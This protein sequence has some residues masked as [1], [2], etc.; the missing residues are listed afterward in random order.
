MGLY[1]DEAGMVFEADSRYGDAMG[2]TP[3]DAAEAN[4]IYS[5]RGL[6]DRAA[7]DQA[8]EGVIGGVNAA[9]TG[10]ESGLTL[11]GSDWLLGKTLPEEYRQRL[12]GN[13]AAHPYLRTGGEIAG[14]LGPALMGD[15]SSP[16]GYLSK[17]AGD[18]AEEGLARGGISGVSKA[19]GVMGVEGAIQSGGQYVGHSAL[20]DTD[21]TAEGLAGALGA[22]F[23]FG[24]IG[25]GAALGVSKGAMAA[26]KLFAR[27]SDLA[28][29]ESAWTVAQQQALEADA[30]TANTAKARLDEILKAKQEALR[31]RNET[32]AAVRDEQLRGQ[33]FPDVPDKG[34]AIPDLGSEGPAALDAG[35]APANGGG[36]TSVFSRPAEAPAPTTDIT[37]ADVATGPTT[38]VI[39]RGAAPEVSTLESQLAGTKSRLDGGES[40]SDIVPAEK[41][42]IKASKGNASD[43]IEKWLAEARDYSDVNRSMDN[44]GLEDLGMRR[45]A[46]KTLTD[47]RAVRTEALL[48][49]PI[50]ETESALQG[51]LDEFEQ[52]RKGFLDL[53]T[54]DLAPPVPTDFLHSTQPRSLAEGEAAQLRDVATSAGKRKAIAAVDAAHEEAL[55]HAQNASDPA[56]AGQ[57]LREADQLERMITHLTSPDVQGAGVPRDFLAE[58]ADEAHIINRYEKSSAKLADAVGEGAHPISTVKAKAYSDAGNDAVRKAS[59]RTTRALEDHEVF[60]PTG[61]SAKDRIAGAKA[62]ANDAARHYDSASADASEAKA[63]A[64][65]ASAKLGAS[66][67]ARRAALKTDARATTAGKVGSGV[68]TTALGLDEVLNI[69]GMPKLSDLPV[70][71]PL[72][73]MFLKFRL[74]KKA[75]GGSMGK[76]AATADN[77]V[78]ALAA[79]TQDRVMRAVDRSVGA[80]AA[81]GKYSVR[82][83]PPVAGILAARIY[84]NGQPT[85]PKSAPIGEQ[86]AARIKELSDYVNTPGAI[87]RDV[88]GQL[89]DVVDPDVIAAAEKQRRAMMQYML[90]N[91]PKMPEQGIIPTVKAQP[92]PAEAMAFARRLDAVNDPAGVYERLAAKNAMLS[93]EA[94]DALQNV[95]PQLFQQAQQR[96]IQKI[97]EANGTIP[98]RTRVQ[99]TLLYKLPFDAALSPDSLQ[100][101]QSVYERKPMPSPDAS[102]GMPGATAPVPPTPSIAGAGTNLT[103]LFETT[104]DR[105]S[106]R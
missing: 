1:R 28:G 66:E 104:A 22:G 9:L 40:L 14:M 91:A 5:Q 48:G 80:L 52:A 25:G 39:P 35:I 27:T 2:Y 90:D 92:S 84:D 71:G 6:T 65:K 12:A 74:L 38:K 70:V 62:R 87:E 54:K 69:P 45:S 55:M 17:A 7:E 102:G 31:Y 93:L 89:A 81:G 18:A 67:K 3:V 86:A 88:R 47:M 23:A 57:A 68:A 85:P 98:Y 100:I 29:A 99:M 4:S 32:R 41:P 21:A 37:P 30:T 56:V 97:A 60:G 73:G 13:V 72:L 20:E 78:A 26:R 34:S 53:T 59:D 96:V 63:E 10:V 24:S 61:P 33:S 42:L 101:S 11:G 79:R 103:A 95:Y 105:R 8:N 94:A 83:V 15:V 43:S 76:I 49:K 44:A 82:I 77:R 75:L 51:A 19:L 36:Q 58:V 46:N 16:T 64:S 106:M 50:A